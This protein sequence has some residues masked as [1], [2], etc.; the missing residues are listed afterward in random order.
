MRLLTSRRFGPL[1]ATQFLGALNDNLYKNALVLLVLYQGFGAVES[2]GLLVNLAAGLFILP[3]LLLSASAGHWADTTDKA[4]IARLT[5][6]LEVAVVLLGAAGLLAGSLWLSLAALTLLG[7]Q[8]ALFGPVKYGVLP[9]HL[10]ADELVAGNAW[11]EAATFLAILLGTLVAGVLVAGEG[12][13]WRVSG[14]ALLVAV[15]GLV[16]V[17]GM[18]PAPP[19]G[20]D[21]GSRASAHDSGTFADGDAPQ[22]GPPDSTS[23]LLV[24]RPLRAILRLLSE[25]RTEAVWP[26]LLAISWF[27]AFGATVLTQLPVMVRDHLHGEATVVSAL[28]AVFS[29]GVGAGSAVAAVTLRRAP[30]LP[31]VPAA[32]LDMALLGGLL[33]WLLPSAGATIPLLGLADWWAAPGSVAITLTLFALAAAGGAYCVPLYTALQQLAA[34]GRRGRAVA[35]NNV[36]NSGAMVAAAGLGAGLGSAGTGV[37]GL[38]ALFAAGNLPVAWWLYRYRTH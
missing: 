3:F 6:W 19:L 21:T 33:V 14:L 17:H 9:Q 38:V 22:A 31:L 30:D 37:D 4:R 29:V 7:A 28:L 13:V 10:G 32:A 1:F 25:V 20:S 27:W 8:S 34:P 16:A 12:A 23:P 2:P 24:G 18:P 26:V 15:A 11:I 36:V 5:K 35:A